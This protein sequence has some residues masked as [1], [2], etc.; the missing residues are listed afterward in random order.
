MPYYQLLV[1]VLGVSYWVLMLFCI[2]S[3]LLFMRRKNKA[4]VDSNQ[5]SVETNKLLMSLIET[6]RQR[7]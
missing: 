5:L 1:V 4:D 6:L 7:Q 2:V 3:F